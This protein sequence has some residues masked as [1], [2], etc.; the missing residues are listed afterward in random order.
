M[1]SISVE[2]SEGSL[3]QIRKALVVWWG[4]GNHM[5]TCI[6]YHG[7]W[8]EL[9]YNNTRANTCQSFRLK[10]YKVSRVSIQHTFVRVLWNLMFTVR[11]WVQQLLLWA[12][13]IATRSVPGP[14]L[15][16][17]TQWGGGGVDE[18][19]E[20]E[21]KCQKGTKLLLYTLCKV[22]SQLT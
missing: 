2:W 14:S 6:E 10:E 17:C 20:E 21:E 11:K 3:M 16:W 7:S 12:T 19:R 15:I 22:A 1:H 9:N 4:R 8:L 13:M 18:E 5:S